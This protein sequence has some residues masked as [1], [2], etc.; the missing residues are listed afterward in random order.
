[1]LIIE[2]V[3]EMVGKVSYKMFLF[4]EKQFNINFISKIGHSFLLN[5][6]CSLDFLILEENYKADMK[7]GRYF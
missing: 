4:F 6:Y 7:P 5:N 2:L 1:M 3:H